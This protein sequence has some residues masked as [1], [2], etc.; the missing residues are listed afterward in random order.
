MMI[1]S[2]HAILK[3]LLK[4]VDPNIQ[5][6]N[7]KLLKGLLIKVVISKLLSCYLNNMP[8]QIFRTCMMDNYTELHFAVLGSA[9]NYNKIVELQIG[10]CSTDI[11]AVTDDGFTSLMIACMD[12]CT[13]VVEL[14]LQAGANSNIQIKTS[15]TMKDNDNV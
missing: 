13:D 7:G 11:D 2:G 12:G 6:T 10:Q 15:I 3:S 5:N 9:E 14:L 8:I 4:V 1:A